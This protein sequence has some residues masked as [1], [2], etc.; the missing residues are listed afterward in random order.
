M[1]EL[2]QALHILINYITAAEMDALLFY[3]TNDKFKYF[4]NLLIGLNNECHNYYC[5]L[6]SLSLFVRL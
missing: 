5:I 4:C 3:S 2:L 1:N 6:L